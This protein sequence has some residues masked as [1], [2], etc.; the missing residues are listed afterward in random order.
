[1]YIYIYIYTYIHL[2]ECIHVCITQNTGESRRS[3]GLKGIF[4]ICYCCWRVFVAKEA[5][6][7]LGFRVK[8]VG[9]GFYI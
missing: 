1:M 2:Y 8:G 6:V 3:W 7:F 5:R 4:G 9:F